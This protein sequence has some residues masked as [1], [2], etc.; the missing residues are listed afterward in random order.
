MIDSFDGV[1]FDI[2]KDIVTEIG[3][4][5]TDCE[6]SSVGSGD[7]VIYRLTMFSTD[8]HSSTVIGSEMSDELP[9]SIDGYRW[10]KD[11]ITISYSGFESISDE[12][13]AAWEI[14]QPEASSNAQYIKWNNDFTVTFNEPA[15]IWVTLKYP[16][17]GST[18]WD[19][20]VDAYSSTNLINSFKVDG[21]TNMEESVTHNLKLDTE[22]IL[23][24]GVYA[25]GTIDT[26]DKEEYEYAFT[27]YDDSKI[28]Q[29]LQDLY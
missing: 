13:G 15:Y 23:Q 25:T 20:Y 27:L 6:N 26:S 28:Q 5:Q 29:K 7:E 21:P 4:I 2:D 24:K 8:D 1:T 12:S 9:L 14:T 16:E 22:V 17:T 3:D 19:K 10:S 11:N 18:E